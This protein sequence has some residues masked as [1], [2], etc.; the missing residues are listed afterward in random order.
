MKLDKLALTVDGARPGPRL[1][2]ILHGIFFEEIN[3]A[4][5][6]GLYPEKLRNR[7][8]SE[9]AA[10][11]EAF[12]GAR[13]STSGGALTLTGSGGVRTEGYWGIGVERGKKLTLSL[14]TSQPVEAA[15]VTPQGAVL[16]RALVKAGKRSVGVIPAAS[17]PNARLE[18]RSS[19]PTTVLKTPSLMPTE[20]LGKAR[21]RKDLA[22]LVAKMKPS[23]VRFPGGCYVEGDRIGDRFIWKGTLGDAN[24]RGGTQ[25]IWGYKATNG[26]GFHEYLL[27]KPRP[28]MAL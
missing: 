11:W 25:C 27:W 9:G 13:V 14:E 6:G 8:F 19:A 15:L 10:H 16:A 5:D 28:P 2:P 4:G 7:G 23:F 1:S 26:L 24:Q 21:L 12:G 22:G 18:L 3:H 20:T 17:C